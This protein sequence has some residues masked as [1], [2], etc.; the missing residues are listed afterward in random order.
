MS[1]LPQSRDIVLNEMRVRLRRAARAK[2]ISEIERYAI[3][4]EQIVD[5]LG[6]SKEPRA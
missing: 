4:I 6:E 1:D 3:L 2:D 5:E